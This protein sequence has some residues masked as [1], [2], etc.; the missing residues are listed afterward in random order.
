MKS[1]NS[2]ILFLSKTKIDPQ[3]TP[4]RD[5]QQQSPSAILIGV[6]NVG[7]EGSADLALN[8][9]SKLILSHSIWHFRQTSRLIDCLSLFFTDCSLLEQHIGLLIVRIKNHLLQEIRAV[10][11]CDD[12]LA[13]EF[14]HR[15]LQD[16][17]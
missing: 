4:W 11:I 12:A 16:S 15:I 14:I 3:I 10:I 8:E 7:V 1:L 9:C 17:N 2:L 6:I 13:R 5:H